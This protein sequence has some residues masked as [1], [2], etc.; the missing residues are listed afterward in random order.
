M[1]WLLNNFST[2]VKSIDSGAGVKNPS[3]VIM[4]TDPA[5]IEMQA[6]KILALN[7]SKAYAP[8]NLPAYLQSAAG[9]EGRIFTPTYNIGIIDESKMTI[10]K[11]INDVAVTTSVL[12]P[13]S[14]RI[15]PVVGLAA[16]PVQGSVFIEFNLPVNH[17]GQEAAID[18]VDMRGSLV[19]RLTHEVAGINNQLSW[20]PERRPRRGDREGY[21]YRTTYLRFIAALFAIFDCTVIAILSDERGRSDERPFFHFNLNCTTL[22]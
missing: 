21:V 1:I 12:A 22:C 2:Y 11:M 4:S 5:S 6:I 14:G 9:V 10:N 8:T 15:S 18:I 20:P 17:V 3:T 7:K 19:R 16:H 13:A